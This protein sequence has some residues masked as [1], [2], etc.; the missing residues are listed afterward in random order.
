M[1]IYYIDRK[2]G[3]KEKEII[4]GD[5]F[6]KWVID[7]KIGNTLL[8]LII[9]K[10][11]FSTFYGKL[12]DSRISRRKISS[13]VE[14]FDINMDEAEIENITQ[15]KSF[16]DFFARKLKKEA[17]PISKDKNLLISPADGKVLAYENIDI[18]MMLQVKGSYYRLDELL[19]DNELAREYHKGTCIVVRLAPIDYH[20]FHFPDSGIPSTSKKIKGHYYSVNP[21]TLRAILEVYCQNKREVS[22]F[23][24]DNFNKIVMV[25]VGATCV[26][27]IVQTY[28]PDRH[29]NKG[30]E[31][32]YFK[33]G[34]STV[35]MLIKEGM[36]KID[37]DI[38]ENTDNG[39][40]TKVNMGEA[41][42]RK[43][44]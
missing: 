33:F 24:S 25:E 7:T 23:N 6:L 44:L 37:K 15:Y 5:R 10:K 39:Y 21:I 19:Q 18:N 22:V 42:G 36:V 40:E 29:V 35:I 9:K 34:G 11:V 30:E 41:I 3:R 1:S 28:E 32:G 13:F 8:E 43:P 2:T 14:E 17:R 27:S 16:N 31:K 38:I 26:G 12:Q 4:V 20:R